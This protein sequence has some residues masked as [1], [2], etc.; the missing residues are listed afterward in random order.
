MILF[1]MI[2]IFYITIFIIYY[3]LTYLKTEIYNIYYH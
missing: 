2:I 3:L 1:Q